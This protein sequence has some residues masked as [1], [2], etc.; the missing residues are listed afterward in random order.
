LW[1]NMESVLKGW[2][3]LGGQKRW[4]IGAK[5]YIYSR[6]WDAEA[7]HLST[8]EELES[9]REPVRGWVQRDYGKK[10]KV[11]IGGGWIQKRK[12]GH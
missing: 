2:E 9:W 8:T 4:K 10:K 1:G 5:N 12:V 6:G 3:E 7:K 11:K